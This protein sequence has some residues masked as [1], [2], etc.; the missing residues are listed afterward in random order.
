MRKRRAT[1]PHVLPGQTGKIPM[2]LTIPELVAQVARRKR[3]GIPADQLDT[4]R[5]CREA[6]E[7]LRSLAARF[8]VSHE[9]V[10]TALARAEESGMITR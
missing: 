10:R 1:V 8:E 6:G 3:R 7:S 5:E 2:F 9:S 4:L